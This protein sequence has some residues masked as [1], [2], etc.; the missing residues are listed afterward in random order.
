[1][2]H[3]ERILVADLMGWPSD[4]AA[5]RRLIDFLL[6]Q[7]DS[8]PVALYPG[9][10]SVF[11]VWQNALAGMKNR[12][13][14]AILTQCADWLRD[15]DKASSRET[16]RD[17]SRWSGFEELGGFRKSL[18]GLIFR[19]V[20]AYPTF[21][22]EY[23]KRIIASE[24]LRGDR[25][26]EVMDFSPILAAT[27][28]GLIVDLSLRHLKEELPDDF[29]ARQ[30]RELKRAAERRRK[31][32]DKPEAERTPEDHLDLQG[33]SS[34]VD[35]P[36]FS[37]HDWDSLAI[38]RDSQNFWPPSP[39][40]EPF[41][42]LF[43]KTQE[44]AIRLLN[45]IS[46]HAV[47]AWRQL[48]RHHYEPRGTPIPLEIQFPWGIQQ[49]WGG[50]REYLWHRG[51][52]A[53]HALASGFMALDDWC[54]AEIEQDR[55]V[56]ELI[57]QIV[58]GNESVA[59]LG[60]AAMLAMH[61]NR[62]SD[63]VFPIV[64][65]QRLWCADKGRFAHD[66]SNMSASLIGFT[67]P[68]EKPHVDAIKAASAGNVRRMQLPWLAMLYF[69]ST[70][71]RERIKAAILAFQDSLPYEIEEQRNDPAL[72]EYL[73]EQAI[74]WAEIVDTANYKAKPADAEGRVEIVHVNPSASKPENVAKVEHAT[75]TLQEGNLWTW[76]S[77]IF[78]SGKIEDPSRVEGAVTLG[79]KLDDKSLF[80]TV[81]EE[82]RLAMRR[83][84][85]ASTAAVVLTFRE[86]RT[87][88]D[89][90]W[91]RDVLARAHRTPE[92]FDLFW[93]PVSVIPWHQGIFVARGLAAELH[94][95]TFSK[96]TAG[97]LLALVV[98]PLEGAS[99]AAVAQAATLWDSDAKL[100]WA[101]LRLALTL[102]RIEPQPQAVPRSRNQ[103]LHSEKQTRTAL[104]D[105]I[106]FY[107]HG[108]QWLDLPL[109]PPAWIEVRR[110]SEAV[111]EDEF[112]A[113]DVVN[114]REHWSANPVR[115]QSEYA[116]KILK[117]VP[118]ERILESSAKE[119]L[120]AFVV[121]ALQWTIAKNAPLAQGRT[122]R[123]RRLSALRMD[124]RSESNAR[125]HCRHDAC[126]RGKT[127]V[128]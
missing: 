63:T 22:E 40:R 120:L 71:F 89:L 109:P 87:A 61:S 65:A 16:G 28:P 79:R 88:A 29:V 85:V 128:S 92:A 46:N 127:P 74:E 9:I 119:R 102:S 56:D 125:A 32:F 107:R 60:V 117:L 103:R 55:S 91:A 24:R 62:V 90:K 115:W 122:T 118:Y 52:W 114:P 54:F 57:H 21:T 13:S 113:D 77:K 45:G 86:G 35:L 97:D 66:L 34:L 75:L 18:G 1:M 76:A 31:A 99:L 48:H 39:L 6:K 123:P 80:T 14:R 72:G 10:L 25:F 124:T 12:V 23:L 94:H 81:H 58:Q 126:G 51:A 27:H 7:V 69:F 84:A 44:Q 41:H 96:T 67:K 82:P 19:S 4:F 104:K 3:D 2:P 8:L 33:G 47:A 105:V 112:D 50:Q 83:G 93:S 73:K 37:L 30:E 36:H 5:W 53:P 49:F 101:A 108:E 64:T 43:S 42:S 11:E 95:G 20:R 110:A 17:P 70:E 111:H 26:K 15:I 98:H 116:S 106:K 100:T 78:E 68:S 121:G 59:I 38:D